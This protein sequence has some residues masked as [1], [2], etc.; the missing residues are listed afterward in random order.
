MGALYLL[1]LQVHARVRLR[2]PVLAER[3]FAILQE[4]SASIRW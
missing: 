1:P 2:Q 3:W 4:G